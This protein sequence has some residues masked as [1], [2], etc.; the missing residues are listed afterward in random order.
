MTCAIRRRAPHV[1]SVDQI[2]GL[3]ARHPRQGARVHMTR[4]ARHSGPHE[5]SVDRVTGLARITRQGARV[6]IT[7]AIRRRAH[8]SDRSTMSPGWCASR[9]KELAC[10]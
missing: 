5:R 2:A 6:P 9:G 10:P 1:R 3:G 8:T 4:A 7:R